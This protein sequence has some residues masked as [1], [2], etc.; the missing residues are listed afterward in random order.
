ML[1][2]SFTVGHRPIKFSGSLRYAVDEVPYE[3]RE[4]RGHDKAINLSRSRSSRDP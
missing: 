4:Y 2:V 3:I 1:S